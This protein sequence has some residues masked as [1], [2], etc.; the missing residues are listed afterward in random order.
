[1]YTIFKL[2][3]A[4]AISTPEV[5]LYGRFYCCIWLNVTLGKTLIFI[6]V[7]ETN[8][9]R[10]NA[11]SETTSSTFKSIACAAYSN[12]DAFRKIFIIVLTLKSLEQFINGWIFLMILEGI[13]LLQKTIYSVLYSTTVL[14]SHYF[15]ATLII[16]L[17]TIIVTLLLLSVPNS[18]VYAQDF[19]S[20]DI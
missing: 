17:L 13:N 16:N 4:N 11:A 12:T 14:L 18:K 2:Y 9:R 6:T 10:R 19:V 3:F 8:R 5:N 7:H 1:M 15:K 20:A